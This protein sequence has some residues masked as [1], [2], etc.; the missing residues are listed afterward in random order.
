[1]SD[2]QPSKGRMTARSSVARV[3]R[4]IS[5][6]TL[7]QVLAVAEHL[8]FRHAAE[9]LG[10]SQS[11]LSTRIR[12]LEEEIGVLVF[13]R[14]H[15]GVR[16][17]E[18]GRAFVAEIASGLG[19]I[20][21]AVTVAKTFAEGRSG[22]LRIGLHGVPATGFVGT[23]LGNYGRNR[24]GIELVVTEGQ[25]EDAVPAVIGDHVDIALV[26]GEPR[27]PQCHSR[28]LWSEPLV[29]TLGQNHRLAARDEIHWRN[30]DGETFLIRHGGA[31]P[32]VR[33]HAVRRMG[34]HGI[35][36]HFRRV[37]VERD[38]LMQMVSRGEGVTFSGTSLKAVASE[39]LIWRP[40]ADDDEPVRLHALWSPQNRSK[41]LRDLLAMAGKTRAGYRSA[42][43]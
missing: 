30:L 27:A 1:M 8:N 41:T 21:H 2:E 28:L 38:T 31:G 39:G 9:A 22:R 32:L 16:L 33:D 17:T 11:S 37:D 36:L 24:L 14:R 42:P 3:G 26:V 20:D 35:T 5:L 12:N 25:I 43:R 13:E 29:L 6:L 34:E 19:Q 10:M 18:A 7:T 23:L 4:R 40:I 15:R